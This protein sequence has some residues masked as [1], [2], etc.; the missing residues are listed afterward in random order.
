MASIAQIQYHKHLSRLDIVV[1][2]GTL[3]NATA[4]LNDTLT[5]QLLPNLTGCLACLSGIELNIREELADVVSSQ[6]DLT[7]GKLNT[8]AVKT[9]G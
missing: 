2:R 5:K 9:G 6:I 7:T 4:H 3:P 1:P 8:G